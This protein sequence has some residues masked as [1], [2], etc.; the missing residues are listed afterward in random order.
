MTLARQTSHGVVLAFWAVGVHRYKPELGW[1][2]HHLT[3]DVEVPN[4]P[5]DVAIRNLLQPRLYLHLFRD[6]DVLWK[7]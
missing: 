7:R 6:G 2:F 5:V 3:P 4:L 1:C